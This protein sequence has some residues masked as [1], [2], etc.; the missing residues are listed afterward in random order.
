MV[1]HS[2][3]PAGGAYVAMLPVRVTA[4][5]HL[6]LPVPY[7]SHGHFTYS[8]RL[9]VQE[10]LEQAASVTIGV[11]EAVV[12]ALPASSWALHYDPPVTTVVPFRVIIY[13]KST[14]LNS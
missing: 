14:L 13:R 1:Q 5:T 3:Q 12:L 10:W 7:S 2:D 4:N 11:T 6:T 9:Q 8:V